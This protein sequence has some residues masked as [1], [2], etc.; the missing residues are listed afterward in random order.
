MH[1]LYAA[2][3]ALRA[4]VRVFSPWV[5][6]NA[7]GHNPSQS[8]AG[9]PAQGQISACAP[10]PK[11]ALVLAQGSIP[12]SARSSKHRPT[13]TPALAPALVL[14]KAWAGK[15]APTPL[16][17]VH[18]K[19]PCRPALRVVHTA[20]P[21]SGPRLVLSGSVADVCAELERLAAQ[22]QQAQ[23]AM[24]TPRYALIG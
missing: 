22:E 7:Q 18:T 5:E 13:Q 20:L 19:S 6:S 3:S 2:N 14:A 9:S 24:T 12:R 16:L 8:V 17:L 21:G 11:P 4:L 15:P 1:I 23:C 10:Q